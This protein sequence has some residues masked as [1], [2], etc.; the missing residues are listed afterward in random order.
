MFFPIGDDNTDRHRTPYV[1]YTLI[2]LNAVVWLLLQQMSGDS[3]FTYAFSAVPYEI[4]TGEDLV[5]TR[6]IEVG[7][8]TFPIPHRDGPSP[9]Q[10]TL[11]SSMFMHGSW[12]HIIGNMLYLWI[13]GD[14]I[15][16]ELGHVR[17]TLF[18]LACGIA[19]SLAHVVFDTDSVIPSLGASGAIAGVLGAYLVRHPKRG[20]RVLMLNMLTTVPAFIVLGGWIVMQFIGQVGTSAGQAS[21]VAYMA[22]IGGFVAGVLLIFLFAPRRRARPAEV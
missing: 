21:G 15:E 10:L 13:F 5:G 22:H 2:G 9:I 19:A 3:P 17:F 14:Q 12:M 16:D 1:V 4:T 6:S 18:Y 7:G 20:V 11:L 8:Q